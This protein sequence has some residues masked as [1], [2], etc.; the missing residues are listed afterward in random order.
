MV[1]QLLN[2]GLGPFK[3]LVIYLLVWIMGKNPLDL[4]MRIA[5][6]GFGQLEHVGLDPGGSDVEVLE[7][8]EDF[9][10]RDFYLGKKSMFLSG[11]VQRCY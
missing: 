4:G 1:V 3:G 10:G 5:L 2:L 6:G 8:E 7:I 9:Q 11:G